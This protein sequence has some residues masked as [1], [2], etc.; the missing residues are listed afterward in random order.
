MWLQVTDVVAKVINKPQPAA[1]RAER[2]EIL[3]QR[4][5]RRRIAAR[6]MEPRSDIRLHVGA[7][8]LRRGRCCPYSHLWMTL[9]H[10]QN[11]RWLRS[12]CAL[13]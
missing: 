12:T 2:D 8:I 3:V 6:A 9:Q 11:F 13:N 7:A 10:L 4:N 5:T 1:R